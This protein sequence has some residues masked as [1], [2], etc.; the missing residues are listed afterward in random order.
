[1]V[2]SSTCEKYLDLRVLY[3]MFLF[4]VFCLPSILKCS[5]AGIFFPHLSSMAGLLERDSRECGKEQ[6]SLSAQKSLGFV[7]V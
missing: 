4:K 7:L 1:M 6:S 2:N 5:K 3:N